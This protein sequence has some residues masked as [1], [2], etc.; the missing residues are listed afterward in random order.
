MEDSRRIKSYQIILRILGFLLTLTASIVEGIDK[1]T[2]I[3]PVT[4]VETLPPLQV[5][6]TA[7]WQ[8]VSAFVYLL[9]SNTIACSYAAGSLIYTMVAARS[10]KMDNGTGTLVIIILDMAITGL[11]LSANGA[12]I[13]IAVI[14]RFGNSHLNWKK[15]CH[16]YSDFCHQLTAAAALSLLAAFVFFGLVAVAVSNLHKRLMAST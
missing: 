7:K 12:A 8:Y 15:V 2:A 16:V 9:V 13:G 3:V 14:G 6:L 4:I 1:E 11:L 10:K 5:P